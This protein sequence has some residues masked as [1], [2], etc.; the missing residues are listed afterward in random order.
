MVSRRADRS[1]SASRSGVA[2]VSDWHRARRTGRA[3][4]RLQQGQR[5]PRLRQDPFLN[6]VIKSAVGFKGWIMSDWKSVYGWEDALKGLDQHSGVQLDEQEW[7]VGPLREAY[8]RG[9]IP[10]ARLSDMV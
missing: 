2:G 6:G 10:K 1:R 8:A 5:R 7:F 3:D 9:R 4:V